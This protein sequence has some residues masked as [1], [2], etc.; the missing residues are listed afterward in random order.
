[1]PHYYYLD[2]TRQHSSGQSD[3]SDRGNCF[4]LPFI[5]SSEILQGYFFLFGQS[6]WI[7]CQLLGEKMIVS[8]FM[9]NMFI[10]DDCF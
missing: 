5:C 2:H 8:L 4:Q 6:V 7:I 1:M 3:G 9:W 10:M